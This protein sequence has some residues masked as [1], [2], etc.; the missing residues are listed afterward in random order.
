MFSVPNKDRRLKNK[1][2]ILAIR[3]PSETDENIAISS[4][5][6]R[7]KK[8]F[9]SNINGESFTVFTDK[10]GAHRAYF[11]EELNFRSYDGHT[12][13]EDSEGKKWK[14]F[15]SHLESISNKRLLKVLPTHNAFWFGYRAAFPKVKLI[16][17]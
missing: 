5:F 7:K 10:S 14:L 3:L 17:N 9:K 2:E 11:T 12:F 16:K 8:I 4:K 1:Q 15:E 13:A 6:L